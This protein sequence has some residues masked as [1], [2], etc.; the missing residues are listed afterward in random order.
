MYCTPVPNVVPDW[1]RTP[2][3]GLTLSTRT[4]LAPLAVLK[5]YRSVMS[6]APLFATPGPSRWS[7]AKVVGTRPSERMRSELA[8]DAVIALL[9]MSR[10]S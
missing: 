1:A 2:A 3:P 6:A 9:R 8:M 10:M 4:V 5:A 7:A